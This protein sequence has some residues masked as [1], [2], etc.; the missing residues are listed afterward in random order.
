MKFREA[1]FRSNG[2]IENK[3]I[4]GPID[5][6]CGPFSIALL[7]WVQAKIQQTEFSGL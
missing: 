4:V 3:A 1:K 2:A 7:F 5:R 6:H